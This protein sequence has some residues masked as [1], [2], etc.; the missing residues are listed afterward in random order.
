MLYQLMCWLVDRRLPLLVLDFAF[1]QRPHSAE[2]LRAYETGASRFGQSQTA[3]Q[4]EEHWLSLPILGDKRRLSLFL[5]QV[6]RNLLLR[7]RDSKMVT[8]KVRSMLRHSLDAPPTLAQIGNRM[9]MTP[10]KLRRRLAEEGCPGFLQLRDLV[11][12]EAA[13]DLLLYRHLTLE[14]I[15]EQLGFAEHSTFHRAF[16]RW[17]GLSPGDFRSRLR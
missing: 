8:D 14:Q 9:H 15:A 5:S 17:T 16:K 10:T 2:A 6:P 4:L 13:V 3:M 1:E 11:R 12:H 7:Y